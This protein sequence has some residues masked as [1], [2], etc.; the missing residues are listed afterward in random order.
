MFTLWPSH[1]EVPVRI[2]QQA[3]LTVSMFAFSLGALAQ[4]A[5]ADGTEE[6][7]PETSK[8]KKHCETYEGTFASFVVS[9]CDDSPLTP[10]SLCTRGTLEGDLEGEYYFVF[11]TM[12]P[13]PNVPGQLVYTGYS[14]ITTDKG[15]IYTEDSGHVDANLAMAADLETTAQISYGTKKYRKRTGTFVATGVLENGQAGGSYEATICTG[16]G[17]S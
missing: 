2:V 6:Q 7:T 11:E 14:V 15:T 8:S 17:K 16:K 10:Q 3:V 1:E 4:S 13:D 5:H 12:V 9:P